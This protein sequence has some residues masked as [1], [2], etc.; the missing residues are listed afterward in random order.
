MGFSVV[1]VWWRG[2]ARLLA[3]IGAAIGVFACAGD[4]RFP[5]RETV[6]R[7]HDEISFEG[8]PQEYVSPFAW[9]GADQIVFRPVANFF[10]VDPA[11]RAANVNAFDE[12]PDSSWFT[13]RIGRRPLSH[14]EIERGS[15]SDAPLDPNMADGSWVVDQ[16]KPNGANPG[17][18][19]DVPGVGKFM[20]KADPDGEPERATGATSIASRIYHAAGYFAPCDSVVYFRPELLKLEPGLTATDNSGV[21]RPFDR[22]ALD[23]VLAGASRR[24]GLIRMGASAWLPGRPLGPYRYEGTRDDDPNDVI[25]HED[26]RELRG[27]RV[28]AAWLNHFDTREQN[29]MDVFMADPNKDGHGYVRHYILDLGDCFGSVWAQDEISKRLGHAYYLDVP[30][31]A[32]DFVTFGVIERP[33]DRARRDAGIFNYF[34]ARDFEPEMWRGGYPNPAFTRMTEADGAWMARIIARFSDEDIAA[35]VSVGKYDIASARY[36]V[37]TLITRRDRILRRY[38]QEL[39]PIA[40]L[41]VRGDALCGVDL[42]L[43]RHVVSE[44]SEPRALAAGIRDGDALEPIDPRSVQLGERGAFCVDLS[45][46]RVAEADRSS[47]PRYMIVELD[48]GSELPLRA[49]LYDLGRATALRLVGIERE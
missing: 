12:V 47:D 36:L 46:Q 49:H 28:L 7:D 21:T 48:G 45:G 22:D 1:Q 29:T 2:V 33:W 16:G 30:Y 37:E 44:R 19:I 8:V 18:R 23:Q 13:N 11:G 43:L 5:L 15:C 9:D 17:F 20:L 3:A 6:W 39:S 25:D 35:A 14:G 32:E 27:G 31:V 41:E 4:G 26:R 10:A 40:D 38:F 24:N 42:G 34:S